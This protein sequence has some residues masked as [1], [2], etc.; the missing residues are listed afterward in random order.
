[1]EEYDD[2]DTEK[3]RNK[4]GGLALD[5]DRAQPFRCSVDRRRETGLPAADNC[6]IVFARARTGLQ[7][8]PICNI[9]RVLQLTPVGKPM[10][11]RYHGKAPNEHNCNFSCNISSV[12]ANSY[13]PVG[14][15][16]YGRQTDLPRRLCASSIVEAPAIISSSVV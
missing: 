12:V 4:G 7:T 11:S 3:S 1:M 6:H 2:V 14:V 5:N 9:A 16:T 10:A 13:T 8:E 15:S